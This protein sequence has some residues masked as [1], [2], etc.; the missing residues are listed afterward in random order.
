MTSSLSFLEDVSRSMSSCLNSAAML[1]E[2]VRV[3]A[4]HA[5]RQLLQLVDGVVAQLVRIAQEKLLIH[6]DVVLHHVQRDVVVFLQRKDHV[7]ALVGKHIVQIGDLHQFLLVTLTAGIGRLAITR[8][9]SSNRSISPRS[10][11][12]C[13]PMES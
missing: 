10:R 9:S 2:D 13:A 5:R 8:L 11:S 4:I 7:V 6:V 3:L 12:R 1:L